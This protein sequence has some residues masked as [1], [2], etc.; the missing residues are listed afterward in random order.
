VWLREALIAFMVAT[1]PVNRTVAEVASRPWARE[2]EAP[3]AP[4]ADQRT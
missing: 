4:P 2:A 3:Q 1:A